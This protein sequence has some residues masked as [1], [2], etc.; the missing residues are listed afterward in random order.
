MAAGLSLWLYPNL[1]VGASLLA[2]AAWQP[3]CLCRL[4]SNP[5]VGASLLAIAVGQSIFEL[6]DE[7]QSRASSLPQGRVLSDG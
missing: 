6:N 4:Y 7:L 3:T 1:I 2:K 5:T